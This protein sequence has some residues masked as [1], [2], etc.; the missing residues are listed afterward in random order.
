MKRC[1][2]PNLSPTI[3]TS[4]RASRHDTGRFRNEIL[5]INVKID[6]FVSKVYTMTSL[7]SPKVAKVNKLDESG[8]AA[9]S[10]A[11][12]V[13]LCRFDASNS[14]DIAYK[15]DFDLKQTQHKFKSLCNVSKL[16]LCHTNEMYCHSQSSQ[17]CRHLSTLCTFLAQQMQRQQK[18]S[19]E[20]RQC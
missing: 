8:C 9:T 3:S 16:T 18:S 19:D 17:L 1:P 2:P 15:I 4:A 6:V 7:S 13:L 20:S 12:T 5:L 10:Q 14:S 11:R